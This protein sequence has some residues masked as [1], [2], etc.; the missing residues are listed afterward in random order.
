MNVP[1][2]LETTICIPDELLFGYNN[3]VQ[4]LNPPIDYANIGELFTHNP[5]AYDPDGDAS[6]IPA[7]A[8]TG[9]GLEVP[10]YE[11][12]MKLLPVLIFFPLIRLQAPLPGMCPV[13]LAFM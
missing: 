11:F 5:G 8:I 9:S 2:Y 12:L 6:V 10:G 4:L 7:S 3:S 1:F 13:K